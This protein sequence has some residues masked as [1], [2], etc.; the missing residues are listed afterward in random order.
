MKQELKIPKVFII[1]LNWNGWRD[2][3]GC[4]ESL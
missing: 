1:V 2:T 3:I 4:L